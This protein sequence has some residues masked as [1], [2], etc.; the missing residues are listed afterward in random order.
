MCSSD[1]A[2]TGARVGAYEIDRGLVRLLEEVLAGSEVDLRGEDVTRVDLNAALRS[3]PWTMVANLPYN[4]GTPLVLDVLRHV[5]EITR[6]VVMV[7]KEVAERFVAGPGSRSYGVPSIVAA[8]HAATELASTVPPSVFY[9]MPEIDSAVIVMKRITP[10]T[11]AEQ[12]IEVAATA[13]QQ[14]RKMLRRSLA[15]VVADPASVLAA[16]GVDPTAR[17]EE[18]PPESFLRLA[19]AIA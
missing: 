8:L 9:P 19:E 2:A 13:F 3:G 5:P 4:V 15:G 17:P 6:L 10:P 14:R 18:L 16:A 1:L 12:A 11:G 7:Q